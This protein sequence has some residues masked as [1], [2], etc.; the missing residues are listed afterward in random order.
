M[1]RSRLAGLTWGLIFGGMLLMPLA[2]SVQDTD[3]TLQWV[4]VAS[5]AL[6]ITIGVVLIWVRSTMKPDK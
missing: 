5:S 2:L 1:S 6:A 3:R 4:L